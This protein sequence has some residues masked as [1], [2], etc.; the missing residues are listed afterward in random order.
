MSTSMVDGGSDSA[1]SRT[2]LSQYRALNS[3]VDASEPADHADRIVG[4][5]PRKKS[6]GAQ[7]QGKEEV[8]H[9]TII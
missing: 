7:N 4:A 2:L 6:Y 9:V 1:T 5:S 8:P 3:D